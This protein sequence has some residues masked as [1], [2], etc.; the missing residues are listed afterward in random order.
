MKSSLIST[1]SLCL[2]A[3]G[4]QSALATPI[5]ASMNLNAYAAIEDLA[6]DSN[7][8]S[9]MWDTTPAHLSVS[10]SANAILSSVRLNVSASGSGEAVWA[11]DGNTGSVVFTDYGWN[12]NTG[13]YSFNAKLND[14]T[15]GDDYVYTF[16]ADGNDTFSMSYMVTSTGDTTDLQGWEILW[17]GTGG[18]LDLLDPATPDTSGIF[19]R[20]LIAGKIYTVSLRNNAN[21]S[22]VSGTIVGTMSGAFNFAITE[23]QVPE[24]ASL[25]LLGIGLAGLGFMRRTKLA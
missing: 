18:G 5:S 23:Q 14:H 7:S 3:A 11:S 25:A 24:P 15:A 19:T 9:G 4:S 20:D 10:A 21:L 12:A 13:S 16:V 6:S 22:G 1:L 8:D 2:I 17:D